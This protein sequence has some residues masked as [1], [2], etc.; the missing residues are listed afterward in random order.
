MLRRGVVARAVGEPELSP[1]VAQQGIGELE[2]LGERGV[3]LDSVEGDPENGGI[4]RLE[5]VGVVAEPATL[6]RSARCVGLGIEPEDQVL[7]GE[8]RELDV[9]AAVIRDAKIGRLGAFL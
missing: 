2:L 6:D 7:A 8:V 3:L 4:L 5:G 1:G 9:V